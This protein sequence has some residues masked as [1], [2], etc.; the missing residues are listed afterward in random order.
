MTDK[1]KRFWQLFLM[2]GVL[3]AALT[4][5]ACTRSASTPPPDLAAANDVAGSVSSEQATMDAVRDSLLTQEARQTLEASGLEA[6]TEEVAVIVNTPEPTIDTPG[7]TTAAD[8]FEYVV[9]NGEWIYSIASKFNIDP[10]ELIAEL[11]AM[12]VALGRQRGGE[13]A[14]HILI[15]HDS[16]AERNACGFRP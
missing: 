12:I 4:V 8:A 15:E 6:V 5:S 1:R 11:V 16:L 2:T 9:Q 13:C 14:C 7:A 3:L 10:D